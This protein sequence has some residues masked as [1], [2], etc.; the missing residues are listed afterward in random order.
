MMG[1]I[2][3]NNW[4]ETNI[5]GLF[6]AGEV[7]CT[8][9]HG[10]NRLASNSMLEVV[11]FSK[12]IMEKTRKEAKTEAPVKEA[13]THCSLSQKRVSKAVPAPS[14]SALQRLHWNKVGIIR[15][16]ECLT[17]AADTLAAWQKSLPQPTDRHSYELNNLVL[18]GRL[19]TEAAL[20]RKESRG[21]HFRS[22][23]PQS[24][25]KWQRHIIFTSQK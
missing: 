13:R 11:V 10:A 19:V 20:L 17:E 5:A 1:G 21:A 6:A 12:R 3:V 14:L 22:D 7:A 18:T 2:R 16:Q 9:V 15:N 4:G 24:S 8:G 25:P 23:F